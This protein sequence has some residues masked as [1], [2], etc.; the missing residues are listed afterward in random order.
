MMVAASSVTS[1]T[2]LLYTNQTHLQ[3]SRR[4]ETLLRWALLPS[5][6]DKQESPSLHVVG[7]HTWPLL[8]DMRAFSTAPEHEPI[9]Q[10]IR[11]TARIKA[12]T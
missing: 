6:R 1:F 7:K 10:I 12:T 11:D 5:H 2:A 9:K 4:N 8:W 3:T